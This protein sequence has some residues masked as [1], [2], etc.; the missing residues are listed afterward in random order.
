MLTGPI[1]DPSLTTKSKKSK[2]K[3]LV[4]TSNSIGLFLVHCEPSVRV[5]ALSLLTTAFT[6]TKPMTSEAAHEILKALPLIHAD[7]DAHSR[8]E[9]MSITRKLVVRLRSG[10]K[11]IGLPGE[12]ATPATHDKLVEQ[13]KSDQLTLKFLANYVKFLEGDLCVNASYPRHITALKAIKLL[14]ESGLDP[15]TDPTLSKGDGGYWKIHME[16]YNASLLR[17]LLDLLLDPFEEVRQ[18]SLAIINLFPSQVLLNGGIRRADKASSVNMRLPEALSRAEKIASNTS[19]ADHA[20]T[21][22]RLYHVLFS[23]ARNE[24]SIEAGSLWSATRL[25]VVNTLLVKLEG[26]LDSA[27]GLF[28]SSMREAPLHGYMSGLR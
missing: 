25:S 7:S 9:I 23:A 14:L 18:T 5:A 12:D 27:G 6:T 15:L 19:R 16:L 10:I 8:S 4:L 26:R 20:D 22:A 2:S 3:N 28:N 11:Q 1:D 13:S 24:D 17:L 21:V